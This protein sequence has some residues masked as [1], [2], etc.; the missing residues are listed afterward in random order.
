MCDRR[1]LVGDRD[2]LRLLLLLSMRPMEEETSTPALR[3]RAVRAATAAERNRQGA[4]ATASGERGR[5][6]GDQGQIR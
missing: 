5:E 1:H 2:Q 6:G 4:R 3:G